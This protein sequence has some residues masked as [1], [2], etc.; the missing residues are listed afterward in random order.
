MQT[1]ATLDP[2]DATLQMGPAAMRLIVPGIIAAVAGG[3]VAAFC[4]SNVPHAPTLFYHAYLTAFVFYLTITLGSLFFVILHHLA[5]SGWS[6]IL[7]RV[8]EA[9]SG[10]VLLMLVLFMPI[11]LNLSKIYSW[12]DE[13]SRGPAAPRRK[14]KRKLASRRSK[15]GAASDTTQ[16][17]NRREDPAASR[18]VAEVEAEDSH[19]A[20]AT[21]SGPLP[22]HFTAASPFISSSGASWPGTTAPIRSGKTERATSL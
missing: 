16:R 10:N 11:A 6:V 4:G 12:A 15:P 3:A 14:P 1:H 17:E 19:G 18:E 9:L 13:T 8:A 21:A 5:R 7:R 2:N 20:S 22:R